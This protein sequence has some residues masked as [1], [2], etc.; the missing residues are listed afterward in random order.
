MLYKV[1]SIPDGLLP[2]IEA[3]EKRIKKSTE[4]ITNKRLKERSKRVIAAAMR[5]TNNR[6]DFEKAL[7]K[8]GMSV[9][10]RTKR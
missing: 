5:T 6:A 7:E 2:G 1:K 8:Q 4:I 10:F 9:L 3:L